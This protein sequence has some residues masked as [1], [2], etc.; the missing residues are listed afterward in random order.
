[1]TTQEENQAIEVGTKLRQLREQKGKNQSDFSKVLG[2]NQNAYSYIES[3]KRLP[4]SSQIAIILE[5]FDVTYEW[6]M[7]KGN[8]ND[9]IILNDNDN[10]YLSS[11][12]DCSELRVKCELY[13]KTI[14]KQEKEIEY[15][16]KQ[17][18]F[19]LNQQASL[20]SKIPDSK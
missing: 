2:I 14:E 12:S 8:V 11:R 7:G 13:E 18:D 6:L 20:I 3:G 16:R 17:A 10:E 4:T 5:T 15:L 19:L 9:N 1:M